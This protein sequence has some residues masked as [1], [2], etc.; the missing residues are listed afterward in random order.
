M[1]VFAAQ[2]PSEVAGVVLVDSTHPDQDEPPFL[3]SRINQVPIFVRRLL[4][5][6]VP[7][8][9]RFGLVR[10][11]M[12]K[13]SAETPPPVS[14]QQNA[15]AMQVM[16]N[17]RVKAFEAETAQECAATA[18]GS[19]LPEK[20]SGNPELDAAARNSWSLG[21][22]PLVV[23]TAGRYWKPDDPVAAQQAAAFHDIWVYQ[24]QAE[25]ARLSTRGKQIVVD[26]SDHGIPQ[27][28]P[29]AVVEAVHEVVVEVQKSVE[30]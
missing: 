19:I 7:M 15:A 28:A 29:E 25:L 22:R 11:L 16:H 8:A 1:R 4:C 12:I 21:D 24:L 6:A 9:E 26:G 30:K 27:Q 2:Y 23:L 13:L 17:Q 5:A 18:G 10:L 14:S 20:G 3:R